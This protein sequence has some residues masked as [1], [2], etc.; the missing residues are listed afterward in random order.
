MSKVSPDF[1]SILDRRGTDSVKW[2]LRPQAAGGRDILPMWVADMDFAIP[3]AV[4]DAL[5]ERMRH[6]VLG[7]SLLSD[8]LREALVGW[9]R[10]R[11]GWDI[12][13]G[14]LIFAPAVM[15]AVRAAILAFTDPG[16]EVIVQPPVY[17]PFFDAVKENDRVVVENPLVAA[18]HSYVMDLDHL[19][20]R[21]SE[22]TKMLLLCSPHNPVGRV[23]TVD[24][25]TALA[26]VCARHD[27]TIVCDEIHGD[28]IRP[29]VTFT[30]LASISPEVARRT[31]TCVSPSKT[32][33]IAGIASSFV[34][35]E[36]EKLRKRL[37]RT[38]RNLGMD[39][40][41]ALSTTAACAAYTHGDEWLDRLLQYLDGTF[42]WFERELQDR[43]PQIGMST[44]EGTYLAWLDFRGFMQAHNTDDGGI[45]RA[46]LESGG[47]WLSE[48]RRFGAAGRGFQRMN[49][50]C[51]RSVVAD[52]FARMKRGLDT[53]S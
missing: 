22:R 18:D 21:I 35:A 25:L 36:D 5:T 2:D 15:Q 34:V 9:Q 46:L 44:I 40:P 51:P 28:L 50:A 3:D 19:Q 49:L 24:E 32:F 29:G 4:T 14:W 11:N 45:H 26:E 31:L 37:S 53:L 13:P 42:Q 52:G 1:D 33:N 48:G 39:L 30:A 8:A 6:P 47:L 12:N 7:Y 38:I 23:W 41:N 17:F 20:A 16:D 10:R 27:I 43:F